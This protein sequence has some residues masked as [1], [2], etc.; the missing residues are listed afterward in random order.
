MKLLRVGPKNREKPAILDQNGKI[1]DISSH[2]KDFNP[3]NL[4]FE[5]IN[6]LIKINLETLPELSNSERIGPCISKPGKF[7]AIGLNYSD[8][9][10]ETGAKVPTE[11]IIFMKATSSIN[12][13]NDDIKISK[14]SKKLDWEVELGI[15]IG[16][17]LKNISEAEASEYILGY[18]MV[19][20]VSEREWQIE[21][22]GQW[23]KG[24]SND[25]F[26]PI[27]PYLV[28]KDEISDIN[29]LNLSLDVNGKRMQTGNSKTM[30]F[31]V[32]FIVSYL[33]KFMSLQTGDIITTGTPPGVGM[34]M[35]PQVFLK[36][37][38]KIRLSI[39]NLGEQNSK[40]VPE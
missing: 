3:E 36:S 1:R 39:D 34:G 40:V 10:K 19:N 17:N 30:I 12:G 9:A 23:V 18:C 24:K 22:L 13:P 25:T 35:K 14:D 6:K 20:D 5:T 4:N 15:V 28:T 11:P 8:H 33:S 32:N 31:N 37:G 21:K 26:G 7:I 29:N 2:I 38:D 27:G 16:K